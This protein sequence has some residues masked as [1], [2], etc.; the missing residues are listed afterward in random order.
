[1]DVTGIYVI[2]NISCGTELMLQLDN[3]LLVVRRGLVDENGNSSSNNS[4]NTNNIIYDDVLYTFLLFKSKL[5]FVC[6]CMYVC[7]GGCG[8][9]YT[10]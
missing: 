5:A 1:M 4:N 10:P 8:A 6:V 3:V 9:C 2:S 7:M